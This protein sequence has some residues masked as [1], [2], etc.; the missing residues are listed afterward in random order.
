MD[1]LALASVV[2]GGVV[3][4]GGIVLTGVNAW[5]ERTVRKREGDAAR[6]HE[7]RLAHDEWLWDDRKRAYVNLL[8]HFS[9]LMDA[10]EE[11]FPVMVVERY[12]ERARADHEAEEEP[13]ASEDAKARRRNLR[14]Y[15]AAVQAFGS[16]EVVELAREFDHKA[17][18]FSFDVGTLRNVR[19][20][21]GQASEIRVAREHLDNTREHPRTLYRS[22]SEQIR[23]E[24]TEH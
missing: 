17:V 2:S 9:E 1:W 6:E 5:K 24:L 14:E 21:G 15:D 10:V 12:R 20:Q 8:R 11:T 3:G 13:L 7:R 19:D 18:M 23:V 22:V 4:L 16:R